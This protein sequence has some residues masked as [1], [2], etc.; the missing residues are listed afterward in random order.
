M[1]DE[2]VANFFVV[3]IICIL[4]ELSTGVFTVSTGAVV[5][6]SALLQLTEKTDTTKT[7]KDIL[8]KFL[9]LYN[10]GLKIKLEL[11]FEFTI[12]LV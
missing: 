11:F 5:F 9:I 2:S 12:K 6:S 8:N 3:S 4:E 7:N 1:G 10:F